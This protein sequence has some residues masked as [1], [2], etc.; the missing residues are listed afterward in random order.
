MKNR[1]LMFLLVFVVFYS[2]YVVSCTKL[3]DIIPR[4]SPNDNISPSVNVLSPTNFQ[5][6]NTNSITVSGS[7]YDNVGIKEVWLRLGSSGGFGKVN[8]TDS[9]NTNLV[10]LSEGTNEV[11]VY[12][13]DNAGNISDTNT[14]R[15]LYVRKVVFVSTSGNDNNVGIFSFLPVKTINKGIEISVYSNWNIVYVA[16]GV[17]TPNNG[18][19]SG[20]SGVIITNNDIKLIGGWDSSFNNV[21]GY[22]ELDGE[23]SV[24][25]IIFVTNVS[26]ISLMNFVVRKGNANGLAPHNNGGGVYFSSV[27]YSLVSNIIL[28]NNVCNNIGGGFYIQ[29]S[30]TNVLYVSSYSNNAIKGGGIGIEGFQSVSNYVMGNFSMNYASTHGGGIFLS[31]PNTTL[32]NVDVSSNISSQ[33]GGI[34]IEGGNGI[35]IYGSIYSNSTSS[36]G[37]GAIEISGGNNITISASIYNN[38]SGW[39]GG[40]IYAYSY[41]GLNILSSIITNNFANIINSSIQIAGSPFAGKPVLSNNIIGGS[42]VNSI[43]IAEENSLGNFLT[44]HKLIRNLFITNYLNYLYYETNSSGERYITNT[45]E[46][47]TNINNPSI[48]GATSDS[49]NNVVTNL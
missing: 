49:T 37:G 13:V 25:H 21:I 5:V 44:G 46:D 19:L 30:K 8:G 18:I 4:K 47:W 41:N 28:S 32:L 40:A 29:N 45:V 22:S 3:T 27:S 12:A 11:Y 17:Y 24:K 42:G 36:G 23:Y 48:T 26:N 2:F 20:D 43:G 1:F 31:Y 38:K 15:I 10:G 14:V 39:K 16:Q 33:G 7:A 9:W 35:Y 6:F 34:K